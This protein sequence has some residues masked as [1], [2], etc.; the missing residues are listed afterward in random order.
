MVGQNEST[1]KMDA[2]IDEAGRG[3]IF[4]P[5]CAAAVIWDDNISHS[6]L[7]DSKK[8]TAKQRD[9][10]FDFVI[11]NAVDYS[12]CY[13]SNQEIDTHNILQATQ[14]AMHRCL[15]SMNLDFDDILVDGNYFKTYFGHGHR[16]IVG[17]D[18]KVLGIS[19][20]SILAK[21]SRD[22]YVC[23]LVQQH[24]EL[25]QYGLE[26]HKGYCTKLHIDSVKEYGRSD[27]HRMT[28]KLPYEKVCMI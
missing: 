12:I 4:G 28:F 1:S 16:C 26:S 18:A 17:G 3:C 21:V 8:L 10:A 20:A 15:D 9:V 2:C 22:M 27:W 19:A 5:V 11:D 14:I 7:K 25:Q 13:A 6:L 23:D 24:P